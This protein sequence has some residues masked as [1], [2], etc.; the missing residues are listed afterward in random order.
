MGLGSWSASQIIPK[1]RVE[2]HKLHNLSQTRC[3]DYK[4][5]PLEEIWIKLLQYYKKNH[6]RCHCVAD[7]G[8]FP[9]AN[10]MLSSP[11]ICCVI[12]ERAGVR[13]TQGGYTVH[14]PQ[15]RL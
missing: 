5:I 9:G 13:I 1:D 6:A 2:V 12:N 14:E 15:A 10:M 3:S 8:R 7:C 11:D 4:T